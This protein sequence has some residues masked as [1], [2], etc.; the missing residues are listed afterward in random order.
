MLA[1]SPLNGKSTQ[2]GCWRS[3]APLVQGGWSPGLPSLLITTTQ[4]SH[5]PFQSWPLGS[6]KQKG[7]GTRRKSARR[8]WLLAWKMASNPNLC[9]SGMF[10]T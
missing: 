9:I 6:H 7:S 3:W 8:R 5:L 10:G 4:V 2:L 1:A